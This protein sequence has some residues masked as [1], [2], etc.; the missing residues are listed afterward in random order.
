MIKI[1]PFLATDS[2]QV[3]ALLRHQ[4]E[5][6]PYES[7]CAEE[8]VLNTGFTFWQHWL[9]CAL[10]RAP[11]VYVAKEAGV[12]LGL[13]SLDSIGKTHTCWRIRHL[14]VHPQHRGRGI[15]QE[16]LRFALAYFGS[17]GV[18]HF[19]GEVSV[20]NSRGLALFAASGFRRMGSVSYYQVPLEFEGN[21][22]ALL[23]QFRLAEPGDQ[24]RLYQLHQDVLPGELRR[25]Y[26]FNAGDYRVQDLKM[27]S[28]ASEVGS[29]LEKLT[30]YLV[31][32]KNWY[33]VADDTER[34][35]IS[36]AARITAHREGDYH[37]EFMV[38]PGWSHMTDE[39]VDF[40]LSFMKK[41]GMRGMVVLKAFDYQRDL[42]AALEKKGL[43][44]QGDFCLLAREHW[45]RAKKRRRSI[46]LDQAV[47]IPNLGNA[48]VNMPF[49]VDRLLLDTSWEYRNMEGFEDSE[50]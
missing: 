31:R 4:N 3:K 28:R 6:V 30:K 41:A 40:A 7:F 22:N 39:V 33:W 46:T 18:G 13:I 44:R 32:S 49:S 45:S 23:P 36:C 8:K 19:L 38:N 29:D 24:E 25:I 43:E 16:L 27:L 9:P 37:L 1:Q 17:Q 12:V 5:P 21:D 20:Q 15:G 48:A 47:T 2:T 50:Q 10:H 42:I 34:N 11:S 35:I 14:V 26:G